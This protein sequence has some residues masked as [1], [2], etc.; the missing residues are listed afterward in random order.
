MLPGGLT[1]CGRS[2]GGAGRSGTSAR[3]SNS[4]ELS[5]TPPTFFQW[6]MAQRGRGWDCGPWSPGDD[7]AVFALDAAEAERARGCCGEAFTSLASML[8]QLRSKHE[9]CPGPSPRRARHG[10]STA[11]RRADGVIEPLDVRVDEACRLR[12]A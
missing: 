1:G 9:P 8:R 7:V 11:R 4:E 6:L 12:S 10:A 5:W 3:E 2:T